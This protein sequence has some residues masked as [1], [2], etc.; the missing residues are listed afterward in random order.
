V[1]PEIGQVQRLEPGSECVL[2][3]VVGGSYEAEQ[4]LKQVY[5]L[6]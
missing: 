6:G 1:P 5:D 3:G 2:E 4:S